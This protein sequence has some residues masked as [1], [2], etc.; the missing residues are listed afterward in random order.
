MGG[1]EFIK[2]N[3]FYIHKLN[4][5][6]KLTKK[7]LEPPTNM[8][9]IIKILIGHKKIFH[10]SSLLLIL[11]LSLSL[12]RQGCKKSNQFSTPTKSY[13]NINSN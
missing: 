10:Y 2:F 3:E 11:S 7:M 1:I 9:D 13:N 6:R 5:L 4:H 8:N 12:T